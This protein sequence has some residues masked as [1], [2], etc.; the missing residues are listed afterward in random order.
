MSCPLVVV[1]EIVETETHN[2]G[3]GK[4]EYGASGDRRANDDGGDGQNIEAD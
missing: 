2:G 1:C 4:A 3:A